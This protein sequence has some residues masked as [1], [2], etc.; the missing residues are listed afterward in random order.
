MANQTPV[1]MK[2]LMAVYFLENYIFAKI[3]SKRNIIIT[4]NKIQSFVKIYTYLCICVYIYSFQT[5]NLRVSSIKYSL[6]C[7]CPR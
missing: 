6:L 5:S 1:N 4:I 2:T 7:K 3:D